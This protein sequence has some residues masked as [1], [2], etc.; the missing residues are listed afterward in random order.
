[1]PPTPPAC[2]SRPLSLARRAHGDTQHCRKALHRAVQC[3]S[4]YPEHVCEVLLTL[5]QIEGE[6]LDSWAAAGSG[7]WSSFRAPPQSPQALLVSWALPG[8][9]PWLEDLPEAVPGLAVGL[10]ARGPLPGLHTPLRDSRCSPPTGS[11]EDWDAAVQKTENRLAR[12]N[13]QRVKVGGWGGV[14]HVSSWPWSRVQAG[15]RGRLP[16]P[17]H[18]G[19][20]RRGGRQL[21]GGP[22]S[23]VRRALC[24]AGC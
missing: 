13:E 17:S 1:M 12:V 5:E 19:R 8:G 15:R 3:T 14:W 20:G 21:R 18:S 6:R 16:G 4:D 2:S 11:L 9:A 10:C 22:S 24:L 23:W 7:S